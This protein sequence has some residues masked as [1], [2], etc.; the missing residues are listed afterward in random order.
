M[1]KAPPARSKEHSE[2]R[3]AIIFA[4]FIEYSLL[5][6]NTLSAAIDRLYPLRSYSS[7]I[8]CSAALGQGIMAMRRFTASSTAS[9]TEKLGS[10]PS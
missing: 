3:A 1:K 4:L 5:D 10:S 8:V 9:A 6:D 2:V 7:G